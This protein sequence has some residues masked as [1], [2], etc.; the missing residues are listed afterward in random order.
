[1]AE[2]PIDTILFIALSVG[3][4][5]LAADWASV[6]AEVILRRCPICDRD[7]ITGHGRRQKQAHD[8]QHDWIPIRRGYCQHCKQSFTFLPLFSLPYTHYSLLARSQA[9]Q[10]RFVE[11]RSWESAAPTVKDPDRVADPST[12]RRWCRSL[13]CSK[14]AFSFLRKTMAAVSQWLSRGD[15][16]YHSDLRLSWPTLAPFLQQFWPLRL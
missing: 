15:A 3:Q 7:S 2:A 12:L 9:L 10:R 6:G 11:H 8:E 1:L 5:N 13:D 14:P 4:G 16:I